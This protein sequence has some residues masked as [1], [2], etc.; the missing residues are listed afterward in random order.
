MT[1]ADSGFT[2]LDGFEIGLFTPITGEDEA[3]IRMRENGFMSFYTNVD[4]RIKSPSLLDTNELVISLPMLR[5]LTSFAFNFSIALV[6]LKTSSKL[7][8]VFVPIPT[9]PS[10]FI[11]ILS[12]PVVLN[13]ICSVEAFVVTVVVVSGLVINDFT[14]EIS[15]SSQVK[16]PFTL[17]SL[18]WLVVGIVDIGLIFNSCFSLSINPDKCLEF[19]VPVPETPLGIKLY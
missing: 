5:K 17:K 16:V 13:I 12:V 7:D 9:F 15:S 18:F 11:I 6:G 4:E 8:G 10:S 2:E 19:P 1:T 14:P 3:R